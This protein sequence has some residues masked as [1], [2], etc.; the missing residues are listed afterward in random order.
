MGRGARPEEEEE[1][2][3]EEE[4]EEDEE[5]EGRL[6]FKVKL[7]S[8]QQSC[9]WLRRLISVL[10]LQPLEFCTHVSPRNVTR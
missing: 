7:A 5:E 1:E 2:D 3:E 4:E 6:L 10:N 8:A 9:H